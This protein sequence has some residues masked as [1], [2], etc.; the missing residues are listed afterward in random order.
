MLLAEFVQQE[1]SSPN[2]A[3]TIPVSCIFLKQG[4]ANARAASIAK[5][6]IEREEN[7]ACTDFPS[8][9]WLGQRPEAIL[10]SFIV[11]IFRF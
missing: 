7:S 6:P 5:A 2:D 1:S 11:F 8:V 9:R 4:F 3:D 10:Q